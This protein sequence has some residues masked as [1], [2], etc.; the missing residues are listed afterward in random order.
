LVN[1]FSHLN[2]GY[3]NTPAFIYSNSPSFFL[4]KEP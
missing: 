3:G 4:V 2:L 1:Q